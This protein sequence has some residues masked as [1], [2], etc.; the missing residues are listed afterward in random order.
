M[1]REPGT[2]LFKYDYVMMMMMTIGVSG[3]GLYLPSSGIS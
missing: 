1:P 2:R 3:M